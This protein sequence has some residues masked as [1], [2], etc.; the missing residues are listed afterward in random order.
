LPEPPCAHCVS[1]PPQRIEEKVYDRYETGFINKNIFTFFYR[2]VK[3]KISR[4]LSLLRAARI[5]LF[6]AE[7]A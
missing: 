3:Q 6:N 1:E 5:A 7:A 4:A 2:D